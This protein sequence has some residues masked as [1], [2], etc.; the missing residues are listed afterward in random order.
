MPLVFFKESV[1]ISPPDAER[2]LRRSRELLQVNQVVL[3]EHCIVS[4]CFDHVEI[5]QLRVKPVTTDVLVDLPCSGGLLATILRKY[6][7]K[8]PS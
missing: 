7:V 5:Q 6:R 3:N 8:T 2:E 1:I 4:F